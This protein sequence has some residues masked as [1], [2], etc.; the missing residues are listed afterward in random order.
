M[1]ETRNEL[2]TYLKVAGAFFAVLLSGCHPP[3]TAVYVDVGE[4]LREDHPPQ[5]KPIQVPAPPIGVKPTLVVRPGRPSESLRDPSRSSEGDV[6]LAIQRQQYLDYLRQVQRL[7]DAYLADSLRHEQEA[8][9]ALGLEEIELSD[10]ID[11]EIWNRFID[12]ADDRSPHTARLALLAGFPDP[13]PT[14]KIPDVP[15]KN[16]EKLRFE[17]AQGHREKL[18]VLE[19]KFDNDVNA[20]IAKLKGDLLQAAIVKEEDIRRYRVEND[21]KAEATAARQ[22]QEGVRALGLSLAEPMRLTLNGIPSRTTMLPGW[23]A[24]PAPPKVTSTGVLAKP[25]DRELLIDRQLK[26]WAAQNRYVVSQNPGLKD[27][28]R[29]FMRWRSTWLSGR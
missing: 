9:R 2:K 24:P 17:E 23:A 19:A 28:T 14:S 12:Y 1:L 7:K 22:V 10:A 16:V 6:R 11:S 4:V 3:T 25:G 13:N 29:E 8:R 26:I 18:L 15:M 27:M 5:V 21:R 20:K